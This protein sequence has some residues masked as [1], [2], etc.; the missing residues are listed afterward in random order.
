[1]GWL[2]LRPPCNTSL[3]TQT[4]SFTHCP[5]DN[6]MPRPR[7]AQSLLLSSFAANVAFCRSTGSVTSP[8]CGYPRSAHLLDVEHAVQQVLELGAQP[9]GGAGVVGHLPP[10]GL[11]LLQPD[12]VQP[13][14]VVEVV[15]LEEEDKSLPQGKVRR[16][17][18]SA[19]GLS[20]TRQAVGPVEAATCQLRPGQ[21]RAGA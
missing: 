19:R 20:A 7:S 15:I 5:A 8:L 1:M 18:G 11:N 13:G 12:V 9:R 21:A 10:A 2:N 16:S 4:N 3:R 17:A 6:R 14:R